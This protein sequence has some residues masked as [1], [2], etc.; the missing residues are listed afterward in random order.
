MNHQTLAKT[1]PEVFAEIG[2]EKNRQELGLELIASEN[3]CSEAVMEAQGS[4]L[5]N[6]YAEGYPGKRYY[7]GCEFV[8][9]IE[10]L[11]IERVKKIFGANFAN[12]QPHSGSQ[13][14]TAVYMAALNP[15]DKFLGMDL[16]Q[17]GHLTH[18]SPVNFSGKLYQALHYGLDPKTELIDYNQIEDI[19]KKEKPKMIIAG[20]SAYPRE[21]DF[22]AIGEIAKSIG[23]VFMVDMAHIAGLVAAE[24]HSSPLN[25][26]D[27]VTSTTHKTLRGP[28][29]GIILTQ[30]ETWAKKFNSLIFPGIQGGP[31]E[32][33][34]AAKAVAF[35]EALDPEFKTYQKQV[36]QNAKTLS[37]VLIDHGIELVTGGTDNHLILLK[38]D[39]VGMSGK[40]AGEVL[41]RVMI[42]CNK[43]MIPNDSRS[44]FVT[45]GIRVGTPAVTTRG[46]KEDEIKRMGELI[47]K[48]LK[49]YQ[50]DKILLNVKNDVISLCKEFPL[51][52]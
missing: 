25:Y 43:N 24:V 32:H 19:A 42:T 50:D 37:Q 6:K 35:K 36:V 29:G 9:V 11:A 41:E 8:D 3:Y 1:D 22:K 28:R 21:I 26:A 33:V 16:A 18:G 30:D 13:A 34:I 14:N 45:S 4:C 27:V 46:F 23:A 47:V 7:N 31:L 10:T 38:T 39:S 51:Y 2:H 44:P 12:V 15:G 49:N 5:T 40:E 20:A 52:A 17:G 48:A